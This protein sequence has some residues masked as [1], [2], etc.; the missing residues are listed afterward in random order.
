MGRSLQSFIFSK[1]LE[2]WS[3]RADRLAWDSPGEFASKIKLLSRA[4]S[5]ANW[6]DWFDFGSYRL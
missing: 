2:F 4:L 1:M 3:R 5:V 6:L